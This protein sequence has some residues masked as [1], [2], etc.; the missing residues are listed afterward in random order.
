MTYLH[1]AVIVLLGLGPAGARISSSTHA[2]PTLGN[3]V[4]ATWESNANVASG[5]AFLTARRTVVVKE[6][7]VVFRVRRSGTAGGNAD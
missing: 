6:K 7:R 5:G 2:R 1:E 4:A 3:S